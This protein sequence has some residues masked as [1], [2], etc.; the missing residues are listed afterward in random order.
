MGDIDAELA[1]EDFDVDLGDSYIDCRL[2]EKTKKIYKSKMNHFKKWIQYYFPAHYD[3]SADK[4]KLDCLT[5]D[6][7][8]K[9][10][11][12]ASLK[13]NKKEE[14]AECPFVYI[15]PHQKQSFEHVSGY[16]SALVN[17]YKTE[18]VAIPP[19]VIMMWSQLFAGYKRKIGEMKLNG[20]MSMQEGK[21]PITFD[22]VKFICKES[23]KQTTD[24]KLSI[25]AHIFVLLCWNLVAR[26]ISVSS[27]M[28]DHISWSNDALVMVFP[29]HKG[30]KEG[31][32][33]S[34][35]HVY[36]N[37]SNPTIC[38]ILWL[39]VYVFCTSTQR[40][41]SKRAVF[42]GADAA[43]S[44]FS[45]WLR[46]IF[47]GCKTVLENMGMIID[48]LGTH[49][50]RKGV[51]TF[52][53]GMCGGPGP[54]PIYL[55]AGWSLGPVTSR[56]ILEGGGGD[57]L[58]GRAATGLPI[59]DTSFASLPPHFDLPD[60][61][62]LT[63]AEWEN[64]LPGYST[65]YPECFKQVVPFLLA[66]LIHHREFLVAELPAAHPL[67]LSRAWTCGI[68]TR[69]AHRVLTGCGHNPVS[70]LTATGIPPHIVLANEIC[71]LKVEMT[72]LKNE[73]VQRLEKMPEA[74]AQHMRDQFTI[75]GAVQV[76]RTDVQLLMA[77]MEARVLAAFGTMAH[78]VQTRVE[79][80][81][82]ASAISSNSTGYA[83]FTWG[84]RIHNIP[85]DF[86]FPR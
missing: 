60:G 45:K 71:G 37:P 55:R 29:T 47:A 17:E 19:D 50:F 46:A 52:L 75:E 31:K 18:R 56:Y 33:C 70:G 40:V 5:A 65:Y 38:P 44:R 78:N 15:L 42:G 57:H 73:L 59:T 81:A 24:F 10:L 30:D 39:A 53:A 82:N 61:A 62:V 36:A 86:V 22:A 58:C 35:K 13:R 12:A 54:I 43:E 28:F 49:S 64:V 77:E 8:K 80:T 14:S 63:Q 20:E 6:V 11:A 1:G 41:D 85:Q 83:S 76:T 16:K 21:Q 34:P 2:S 32:D 23:M 74:V 51:A 68:M 25:F 79:A 26:S 7:I 69:E 4:I 3:A 9:F 72:Y 48:W 67:F 27:L 84:G 66:S